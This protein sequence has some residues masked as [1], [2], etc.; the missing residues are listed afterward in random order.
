MMLLACLTLGALQ[1]QA[2]P[3]PPPQ[4]LPCELRWVFEDPPGVVPCRIELA[5]S[6][7]EGVKWPANKPDS[8]DFLDRALG[9]G[10][11]LLAAIDFTQEPPILWLD[12]DLDGDLLDEA[13]EVFVKKG[14]QYFFTQTVFLPL[15]G[16]EEEQDCSLTLSCSSLNPVATLRL[17]LR[18]HRRGEVLMEDR[19]REFVLVDEEHRL[20]PT[21]QD[22]WLVLFDADA[23]GVFRSPHGSPEHLHP[24]QEVRLRRSRWAFEIGAGLMDPLTWRTVEQEL[25][26]TI[27]QW[28]PVSPSNA[29]KPI[30][31]R[32]ETFDRWH[33][34]YRNHGLDPLQQRLLAVHGLE[35]VGTSAAA[36]LLL[37]IAQEDPLSAM[38]KAAVLALAHEEYAEVLPQLSALL[39]GPTEE[40]QLELCRTLLL[41]GDESPEEVLLDLIDSELDPVAGGAARLLAECASDKARKAVVR[42]VK[43]SSPWL[44]Q[45]AYEGLRASEQGPGSDLAMELLEMEDPRMRAMAIQD[46]RQLD[47]DAARKFLWREK[48]GAYAQPDPYRRARLLALLDL[49]DETSLLAAFRMV[50]QESYPW[51][52]KQE[53]QLLAGLRTVD[54]EKAAAKA[55]KS[56]KE[57]ER[58]LAV[59]VRGRIGGQVSASLL[60]RQLKKEK[61][62]R[63]ID[64]LLQGLGGCGGEEATEA[65]IKK[66][67]K[68]GSTRLHA[69]QA[70]AEF[71]MKEPTARA[72][73][74][75]LLESR[76]WEDQVLAIRALGDSEDSDLA[77]RLHDFLQEDVWQVRMAAVV[78]LGK[79]RHPDSIAPLIRSY[80]QE[81]RERLKLAFGQALFRLTGNS[82]HLGA[83]DWQNW[84]STVGDQFRMAD[85][86]PVPV[87]GDRGGTVSRKGFYGMS[88]ES[89]H[90]VLV[91]DKSGS[92]EAMA[93]KDDLMEQPGSRLAQAIANAQRSLE[94]LSDESW[95]NVVLFSSG[96]FPWKDELVQ[97]K[98]S[99]RAALLDFLE[100]QRPDG[101]TDLYDGIE[102]ALLMEGVDRIIVLSDGAPSGG[103]FQTEED[104][105][106]EVRRLNISRGIAIDCVALGMRSPLLRRLAEEHGGRYLER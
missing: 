94:T 4:V 50:A 43:S 63:V 29:P 42:L 53:I 77:S 40:L 14:D 13:E 27:G 32:A 65:L 91:I 105:V 7:P 17:L 100:G 47:P 5:S 19:V 2:P 92:M 75:E 25:P 82:P 83:S 79:L 18:L 56:R 70:L 101:G 23:D 49:G 24:G 39:D 66:A 20:D 1:Q 8:V 48:E 46:L 93:A 44:R 57:E 84:W 41:L 68:R 96:V 52:Q 76:Y 89:D 21:Q 104:I 33:A 97:L 59:T 61:S 31:G 38:R 10:H 95:V 71:G 62:E 60:A 54:A 35:Q 28:Q 67:K 72:F 88:L 99:N 3:P 55:L 90:V 80:Q 85:E 64:S 22:R 51:V 102:A 87:R 26:D 34:H 6:K 36:Q 103:A 16:R 58:N 81:G 45:Q 78:A 106:R 73:L 37:L 11:R 98:K 15:P 30:Q 9:D 74:L 86:I 69:I 12:R